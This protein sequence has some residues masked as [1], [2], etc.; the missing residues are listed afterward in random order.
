MVQLLA[1]S[2]RKE[3]A[4]HGGAAVGMCVW[5]FCVCMWVRSCQV[6]SGIRVL[7]YMVYE[8]SAP[9]PASTWNRDDSVLSASEEMLVSAAARRVWSCWAGHVRAR[10]SVCVCVF[11]YAA[12]KGRACDCEREE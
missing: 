9:K 8:H 10:L 6:T 3:R 1:T 4:G 5:V 11:A 7:R 12:S 2:E